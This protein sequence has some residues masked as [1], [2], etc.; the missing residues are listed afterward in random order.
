MSPPNKIFSR[1]RKGASKARE[2]AKDRANVMARF[3]RKT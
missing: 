3:P 2:A 1:P